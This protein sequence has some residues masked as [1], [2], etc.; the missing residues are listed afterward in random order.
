MNDASEDADRPVE[1]AGLLFALPVSFT[2]ET[3]EGVAAEMKEK[4]L[5]KQHLIVADFAAVEFLSS[6]GVQ[7]L[8][9]LEKALSENNGKVSVVNLKPAVA[10]V[11]TDLGFERFVKTAS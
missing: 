9:S 1:N 2:T 4:V 3:V 11:F 8:L 10:E 7:L 5:D 6:A